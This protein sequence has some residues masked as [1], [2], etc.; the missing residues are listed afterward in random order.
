MKDELFAELMESI[1]EGGQILKGTAKA[2][3][4]FKFDEPDVRLIRKRLALSQERFS[5]LLGISVATL[6]NWEQHRRKP[7]GAARVLLR[8]AARNPKT[9]L[10]AVHG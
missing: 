2:K 5:T 6:R 3:R 7:H 1:T 9:I 8:V 4:A 10:E